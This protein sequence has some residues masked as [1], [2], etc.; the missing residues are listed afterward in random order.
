MAFFFKQEQQH[1]D[2]FNSKKTGHL[3]SFYTKFSLFTLLKNITVKDAATV[4]DS[5]L[6]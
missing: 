1:F 5:A 2:I 6:A 4:K 3:T